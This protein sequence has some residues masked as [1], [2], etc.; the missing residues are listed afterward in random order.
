[1]KNNWNIYIALIAEIKNLEY[2]YISQNLITTI[3]ILINR[4]AVQCTQRNVE[5]FY[6]K[7][8]YDLTSYNIHV[9]ARNQI[10]FFLHW[11]RNYYVTQFPLSK[12]EE[13]QVR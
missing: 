8:L 5:Y 11:Q 6:P 7:M 3:P 2:F 13:R 4:N 9:T 10:H 1:M 12:H